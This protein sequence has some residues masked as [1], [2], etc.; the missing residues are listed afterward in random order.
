MKRPSVYCFLYCILCL[1]S[2]TLIY[3]HLY[4]P[5]TFSVKVF[6]LGSEL[7]ALNSIN[8]LGIYGAAKNIAAYMNYR[9]TTDKKPP[10]MLLLWVIFC[11]ILVTVFWYY[12]VFS[13]ARF[14]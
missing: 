13:V 12:T 2:I 14:F 6:F 4:F 11:P 9:K 7:G 10:K 5:E 1:F 8:P 3:L